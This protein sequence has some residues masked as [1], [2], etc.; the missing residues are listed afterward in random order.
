MN[1]HKGYITII[2]II[3]YGCTT[4]LEDSSFSVLN[5]SQNKKSNYKVIIE[6]YDFWV[7]ASLYDEDRLSANCSGFLWG[8]NHPVPETEVPEFNGNPPITIKYA[9]KE[10]IFENTPN[11]ESIKFH[12]SDDGKAVLILIDNNPFCILDGSEIGD[13]V[14]IAPNSVVSAR[15]PDNAIVQGNPAKIIFTRR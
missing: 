3:L 11:K 14:I 9:S 1:N 13:G 4:T 7:W 6:D 15:I 2:F 8:T 12:W 10:A 5:E